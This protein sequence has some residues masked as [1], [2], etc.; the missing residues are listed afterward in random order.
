M[1]IKSA[2]EARS[3]RDL[4][5]DRSFISSVGDLKDLIT[6]EIAQTARNMGRQ[7]ASFPIALLLPGSPVLA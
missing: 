6:R 5:H 2:P 7:L 4:P 1:K 3:S